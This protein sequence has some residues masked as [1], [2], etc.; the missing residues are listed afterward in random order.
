ML[1][2]AGTFFA[3]DHAA[4]GGGGIEEI[5]DVRLALVQK[6]GVPPAVAIRCLQ[7][8]LKLIVQPLHPTLFL[9][10]LCYSNAADVLSW[11]RPP[12]PVVVAAAQWKCDNCGRK[13]F[14]ENVVSVPS[15][16]PV[17]F[18]TCAN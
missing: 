5:A 12:P 15:A 11:Y 18:L 8:G 1:L 13:K 10:R 4:N 17:G 6:W 14:L 3:T 2:S 16:F 7:S 9:S